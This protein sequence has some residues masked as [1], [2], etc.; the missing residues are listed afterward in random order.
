[1]SILPLWGGRQQKEERNKTRRHRGNGEAAGPSLGADC[2]QL[3]ANRSN[4]L[5]KRPSVEGQH[6]GQALGLHHLRILPS[7][8]QARYSVT[9]SPEG[10]NRDLPGWP[11]QRASVSSTARNVSDR[12]CWVVGKE[13]DVWLGRLESA[14]A[15]PRTR[16]LDPLVSGSHRPPKPFPRDGAQTLHPAHPPAPNTSRSSTTQR[17]GPLKGFRKS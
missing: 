6:P 4:Q 9:S 2:G 15:S 11:S 14:L 16:A 5:G 3:G 13:G 8:T 10:R 1:M 17:R 12:L 7:S